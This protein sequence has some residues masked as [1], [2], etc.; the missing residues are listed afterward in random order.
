MRTLAGI[1]LDFD[2]VIVESMD[3]KDAAFRE[4]F[5]RYAAAGEQAIAFHEQNPGVSR[6]VKF[7]LLCEVLGSSEVTTADLGREFSRIVVEQIVKAPYTPGVLEFLDYFGPRIP[8]FIASS[9]PKEELEIILQRRG[10]SQHFSLALGRSQKMASKEA[11]L[12]FIL[13]RGPSPRP[14]DYIFIGDTAGDFQAAAKTGLDFLAFENRHSNFPE[15]LKTYRN[16]MEI[17][18][19]LLTDWHI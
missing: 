17:K 13:G 15:H 18:A 1:I 14:E 7:Q 11:M 3:I 10:I 6:Y 9:T 19:A 2:G 16:F 12:R 4:I 8:L 5:S